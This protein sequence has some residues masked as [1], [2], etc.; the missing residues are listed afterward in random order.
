FR[1]LGPICP[2]I[3]PIYQQRSGF[4]KV[5]EDPKLHAVKAARAVCRGHTE[6]WLDN[7]LRRWVPTLRADAHRTSP[8]Q[9]GLLACPA[10]ELSRLC[11]H[12]CGLTG[13]LAVG[14]KGSADPR[15]GS[16]RLCASWLLCPKDDHARGLPGVYPSAVSA[17]HADEHDCHP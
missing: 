3:H 9:F 2:N 8:L 11:R 16:D 14:R 4:T 17:A 5:A 10:S 12:C 13:D 7:K 6:T 15:A 1:L